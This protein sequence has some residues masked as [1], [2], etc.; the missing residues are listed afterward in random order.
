MLASGI[1]LQSSCNVWQ[2]QVAE[3]KTYTLKVF[4]KK[5]KGV[6]AKPELNLKYNGT[7]RA[8]KRR[9]RKTTFKQEF[10]V[11]FMVLQSKQLY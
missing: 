1:A 10:S 5:I 9:N 3:K 2:T 8:K 4:V 7:V 11:Q 6:H